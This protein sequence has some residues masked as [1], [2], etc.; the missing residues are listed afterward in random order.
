MPLFRT[1]YITHIAEHD[2]WIEEHCDADS[3]A[4]DPPFDDDGARDRQ[5]DLGGPRSGKEGPQA[6]NSFS[7][8]TTTS[9]GPILDR[10]MK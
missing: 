1:K 6:V 7:S 3:E 4:D 8:S 2:W 9:E 5:G 10:L